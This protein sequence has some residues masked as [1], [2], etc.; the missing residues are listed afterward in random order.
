MGCGDGGTVEGGGLPLLIVCIL[1]L[2]LWLAGEETAGLGLVLLR[3]YG[4]LFVFKGRRVGRVGRHWEGGER[5]T[6]SLA[7][8]YIYEEGAGTRCGTRRAGA[9]RAEEGN[10][11]LGPGQAGASKRA[12]AAAGKGT[13]GLYIRAR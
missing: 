5:G 2:L 8:R 4:K 10:N 12:S 1:G 9:R 13:R 7:G 3:I 6:G 11:G